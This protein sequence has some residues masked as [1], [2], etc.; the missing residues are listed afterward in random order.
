MSLTLYP[1]QE[2]DVNR[3]LLKLDFD[4]RLRRNTN[5]QGKRVMYQ[6]PTGGGKSVVGFFVAKEYIATTGNPVY[7]MA[8]RIELRDQIN[9]YF[10]NSR[11]P[12]ALWHTTSAIKI[13]NLIRKGEK[14]PRHGLLITDEA[15]HTPAE[16]W[17]FAVNAWPGEVLG[18]TATPW[19]M[20]ADQGFLQYD[21]LIC[22]PDLKS[23]T[24][25]GYLSEVL[26]YGCGKP[27]S[28]RGIDIG[29]DY[30]RWQTQKHYGNHL[31]AITR[32]IVR[33][34]VDKVERKKIIAFAM[35]KDHASMIKELF[36]E[37][38]ISSKVIVSG[39][40]AKDRQEAILDFKFNRIQTLINVDILTEGYDCP[41]A[42][43]CLMLRPTKSKALFLQM[44]GRVTRI[45]SL[46]KKCIIID[47]ASNYKEF[48]SVAD[49]MRIPYNVDNGWSLDARGGDRSG[50]GDLPF[51]ECPECES[52]N[53]AQVKE[54]YV[55]E[56]AFGRIC[57][58]CRTWRPHREFKNKEV[59]NCIACS[60]PLESPLHRLNDQNPVLED[61]DEDIRKLY[62]LSRSGN[63]YHRPVELASGE[64]IV[65]VLGLPNVNQRAQHG[66][67]F[68]SYCL[69]F[70]AEEDRL[71]NERKPPI[72]SRWDFSSMETAHKYAEE[73]MK[74]R[75]MRLSA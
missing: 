49:R 54:C 58:V 74:I 60:R 59:L 1:Y 36:N 48:S 51:K 71:T 41:D 45:T 38:N 11:I 4:N 65:I 39:M 63:S 44:I 20:K 70:K 13:R 42:Y 68:I 55:C 46:K 6:L 64:N 66:K 53:P 69:A 28:G 22:G 10:K 67:D 31:R 21:E 52:V 50:G 29:G 56:Y 33:Q 57:D 34:A 40:P 27:I 2:T 12:R 30:N 75:E 16:S 37:F 3:I 19:R 18:L 14:L 7:W 25:M 15:H 5:S 9:K 43:C 72:F 73:Q 62:K 8:Q 26:Y 35:T 23:L 47:G 32:D 17:D 61:L 24:E